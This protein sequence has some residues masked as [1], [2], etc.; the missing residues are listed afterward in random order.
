MQRQRQADEL[1][2]FKSQIN[3]AEYAASL[4]YTLDRRESSRNSLIMRGPNDDKIVIATAEDGH[5]VYFSVRDDADNGSIIDFVQRRQGKNLG[6]VRQELRP[7]IG[8]SFTVPEHQRQP[9]PIPTSRDR[10]K[11]IHAW[12]AA[13]PT[14]AHPHLIERGIDPATLADSRFRSAVRIDKRGNALFPH[15]DRDG[16][17]GYEIKN[18]GFSGFAGGGHKSVWFTNNVENAGRVILTESAID[19]ISHA[20]AVSDRDSAYVSFGGSL[21]DHQREVLREVM[22][23]AH[24]RGAEIVIA[25][26]NDP[27]GHK[28]ALELA[29]LA[30]PG[31]EISRDEPPHGA[32]WNDTLKHWKQR[33]LEWEYEQRQRERER[34]RGP[35]H[36]RGYDLGM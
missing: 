15:Y 36:D 28:F 1:E 34:E 16:L 11:I 21:S 14:Q 35:E 26:D 13:E 8:Q 17:S 27:A 10:Q 6:Q 12:A 32:D 25:T 2:R 23:R 31:A 33:P 3:L 29:Q 22:R 24:E 20:E 5:G 4:G 9:R 19:A 18:A 7:W 30:P